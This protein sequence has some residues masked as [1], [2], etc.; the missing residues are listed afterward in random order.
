MQVA[1]DESG[2]IIGVEPDIRAAGE[3]SDLVAIGQIS[4][5]GS[6]ITTTSRTVSLV[7]VGRVP[8]VYELSLVARDIDGRPGNTIV[9]RIEVK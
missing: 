4:R 1:Y 3:T 8:G 6:V 5:P 2:Q 7:W 9:Q